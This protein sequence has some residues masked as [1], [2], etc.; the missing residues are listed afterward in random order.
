MFLSLLLWASSIWPTMICVLSYTGSSQMMDLFLGLTTFMAIQTFYRNGN[1]CMVPINPWSFHILGDNCIMH[2]CV[3]GTSFLP[4]I[5]AKI[6]LDL[7]QLSVCPKTDD[8]QKY[9][10][11]CCNKTV[12]HP[13][14][15]VRYVMWSA[16]G[17]HPHLPK[18]PFDKVQMSSQSSYWSADVQFMPHCPHLC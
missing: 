6:Y 3:T 12:R 15:V 16:V 18:Y 13:T 14:L 7:L 10:K 4:R 2:D 11:W 17:T 9:A 5:T 1:G 8:I